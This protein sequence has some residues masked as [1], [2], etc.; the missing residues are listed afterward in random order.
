MIMAES[1]IDDSKML[2]DKWI[3]EIRSQLMEKNKKN[4]GNNKIN[5]IPNIIIK[6]I[7]MENNE[8]NGKKD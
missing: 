5:E 4:G 6:P 8:R 2:I 7:Q 1:M 3:N